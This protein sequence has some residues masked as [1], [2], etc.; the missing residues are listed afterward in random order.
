VLNTLVT[1]EGVQ[2]PNAFRYFFIDFLVSIVTTSCSC[3]IEHV[4]FPLSLFVS[5]LGNLDH[6]IWLPV[7]KN[8]EFLLSSKNVPTSSSPLQYE[9][10]LCS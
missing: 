3:K 5:F 7:L 4:R 9:G 2:L 8:L 1:C 6:C 10:R